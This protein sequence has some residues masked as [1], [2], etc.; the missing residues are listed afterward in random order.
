[1]LAEINRLIIKL[2]KNNINPIIY[3]PFLYFI[4]LLFFFFLHIIHVDLFKMWEQSRIVA[5]SGAVRDASMLA[6]LGKFRQLTSSWPTVAGNAEEAPVSV[7]VLQCS[8]NTCQK[9]L[10]IHSSPALMLSRG[11]L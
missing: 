6:L 7:T 1:M 5:L 4:F 8:V 2:L 11:H 10:S 9:Q 3:F